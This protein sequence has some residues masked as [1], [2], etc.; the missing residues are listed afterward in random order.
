VEQLTRNEIRS[1]L[2]VRSSVLFK[3]LIQAEYLGYGKPQTHCRELFDS[4]EPLSAFRT[5]Q[6]T[7]FFAEVLKTEKVLRGAVVLLDVCLA[8]RQ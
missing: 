3:P 1:A 5:I 7:N 8:R 6:G 4:T 2:R